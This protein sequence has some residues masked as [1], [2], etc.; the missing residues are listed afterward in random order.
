MGGP[1]SG[2]QGSLTRLSRVS[3][4]WLEGWAQPRLP[5]GAPTHSASSR[6]PQEGQRTR[7]KLQKPFLVKTTQPHS[8]PP[9]SAGDQAVTGVWPD[10]EG[11]QT[12][13]PH[14]SM[15]GGSKNLQPPLTQPAMMGFQGV[16]KRSNPVF[17]DP[18]LYYLD[19]V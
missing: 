5:D 1:I 3:A 12:L 16:P 15:G 10:S 6:W 8:L 2:V 14:F 19:L 13:R 18:A 17:I 7:Q 4:A 11:K 9:Y